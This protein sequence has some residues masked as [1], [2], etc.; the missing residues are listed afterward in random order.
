M[1]DQTLMK[2]A[3]LSTARHFDY[4]NLNLPVWISAINGEFI[5]AA[6]SYD[7]DVT[8][9]QLYFSGTK[10]GDVYHASGT[11]EFAGGTQTDES[12]IQLDADTDYEV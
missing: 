3:L 9:I 8:D 11:F 10:N 12:D 4:K 5:S 2:K 6:E 7:A 1:D